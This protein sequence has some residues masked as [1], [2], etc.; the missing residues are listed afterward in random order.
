MQ[1]MCGRGGCRSVEAGNEISERALT[2]LTNSNSGDIKSTILRLAGQLVND[3]WA[4]V[5]F[6]S[7]SSIAIIEACLSISEL[8]DAWRIQWFR[9][10]SHAS[11]R[12]SRVRACVMTSLV[13]LSKGIAYGNNPSLREKLLALSLEIGDGGR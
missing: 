12:H 13:G 11:C 7:L 6:G 10:T 2:I 9:I 5:A 8:T 4:A 1:K 3:D